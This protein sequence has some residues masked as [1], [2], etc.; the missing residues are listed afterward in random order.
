MFRSERTR[1]PSIHTIGGQMTN[2]LGS[3]LMWHRVT[4]CE[5]GACVEVATTDDAI[6]IRSS[7]NP[8]APPVTVARDEWSEFLTEAKRG[9]LDS[10]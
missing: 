6:L 9:A 1:P 3:E 4:T 8:D 2:G 5:G 10:L 7:R